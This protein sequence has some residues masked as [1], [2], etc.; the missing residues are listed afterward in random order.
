[1]SKPEIRR[2]DKAIQQAKNQLQAVRNQ[3]M[4][5]LEGRERRAVLRAAAG[6]AYSLHRGNGTTRADNKID[7]VFSSAEARLDAEINALAKARQRIMTEQA[8]AKAAKKS[9]GWW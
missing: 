4:W 2:L 9:S 7:A 1:M 8:T 3:E 6:G 5:P